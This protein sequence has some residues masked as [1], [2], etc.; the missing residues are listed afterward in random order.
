M[1]RIE[2]I[3]HTGL[4]SSTRYIVKLTCRRD[5]Y[6]TLAILGP[7]FLLNAR[8]LVWFEE[9]AG[10]HIVRYAFEMFDFTATLNPEP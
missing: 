5:E 3:Y 10:S 1:R 6:F 4:F 9:T 2:T 7:Y 8:V